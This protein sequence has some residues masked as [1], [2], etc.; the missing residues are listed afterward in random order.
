MKSER[1]VKRRFRGASVLGDNG[2]SGTIDGGLGS[3][4]SRRRARGATPVP[5]VPRGPRRGG[6][7]PSA[8]RVIEAVA[9]LGVVGPGPTDVPW[10]ERGGPA[11][12][13]GTDEPASADVNA[14]A[15]E[16]PALPPTSSP[17]DTMTSR[18]AGASGPSAAAAD[19][20]PRR[21]A[22]DVA[23]VPEPSAGARTA[24][25][26]VVAATAP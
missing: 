2:G 19:V 24:A 17:P 26:A 3:R 13:A 12:Y 11:S 21:L 23:L 8:S 16:A 20:V 15:P 25:A 14:A 10:A 7:G 4:R 1:R 9:G 5:V 22:E 18:A 6:G